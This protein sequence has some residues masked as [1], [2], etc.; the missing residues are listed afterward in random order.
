MRSVKVREDRWGG[1]KEELGGKAGVRGKQGWMG[2][3]EQVGYEG[4]SEQQGWMVMPGTGTRSMQM[5]KEGEYG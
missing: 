1:V 2:R 5:R 3:T 4:M